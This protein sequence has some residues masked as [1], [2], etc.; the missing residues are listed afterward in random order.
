MPIHEQVSAQIVFLIGT[1]RWAPGTDLP[2]VR[3]LSQRLG[4]HRN[5]ITQAYDDLILKLLVEKRAGKRLAIRGGERKSVPQNRNLDD[6]LNSTIREAGRLGFSLQQLHNR[7]RDRLF[8][9]NLDVVGSTPAEFAA[10]L[11]A[12]IPKW[13]KVVKAS[14]ARVD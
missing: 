2:S 10:Y 7:L 6:V 3:A 5:T 14:G 13:A 9:E 11:K 8:A 4:V 12:E 1:G